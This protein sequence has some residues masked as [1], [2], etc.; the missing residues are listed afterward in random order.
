MSNSHIHTRR[1]EEFTT[2]RLWRKKFTT[3][4]PLLVYQHCIS[5]KETIG[6]TPKVNRNQSQPNAT[7]PLN[8]HNNY[9]LSKPKTILK[10]KPKPLL[11]TRNTYSPKR[12]NYYRPG[13]LV[14]R[15][16]HRA[17]SL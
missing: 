1:V 15:C 17:G 5:L 7:Q 16:A 4:I 11:N 13:W 12:S 14:E 6:T 3:N 9:P 10:T 2:A 8:T